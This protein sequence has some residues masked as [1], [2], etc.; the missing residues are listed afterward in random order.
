MEYSG[1]EVDTKVFQKWVKQWKSLQVKPR[2]PKI[3]FED[4]SE[5]Q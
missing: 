2:Y 5:K 1:N 3:P 4:L